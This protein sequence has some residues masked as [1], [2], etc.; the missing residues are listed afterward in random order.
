MQDLKPVKV[1]GQLFWNKYLTEFNTH[2]N[3][4]N[5]KY[6]C[7]LCHL[8][9]AAKAKLEELGIV[10]KYKP[11]QGNYIVAKSKFKFEPLNEDGTAIQPRIVKKAEKEDEEDQITYDFGN[12]TQAFAL[13]SSYR[14]KMSAKFGASPSI[15]KLV[16][17]KVV[18]YEAGDEED[19]IL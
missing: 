19:E 13:V 18:R 1:S 6:E 14:H 9:E 8:S 4:D 17:T 3:E 12:G 16:V 10:V 15:K 5:T 7:T 11:E 2:F